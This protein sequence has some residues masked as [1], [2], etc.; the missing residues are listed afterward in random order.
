MLNVLS[1]YSRLFVNEKSERIVFQE[2]I[3]K[4]T[5]N[6]ETDTAKFWQNLI[7]LE[8]HFSPRKNAQIAAL[9]ITRKALNSKMT[10]ILKFCRIVLKFAK[11]FCLTDITDLINDFKSSYLKSM[12]QNLKNE[13]S[14]WVL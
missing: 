12:F 5:K 8:F 1:R 11:Q 10:D 4:I 3:E 7:K 13:V 9:L 2:L 6:K 14:L